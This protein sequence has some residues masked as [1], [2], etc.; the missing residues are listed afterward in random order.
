[1]KTKVFPMIDWDIKGTVRVSG[2]KE[3][4]RKGGDGP[5][6][7]GLSQEFP[8]ARAPG[9]CPAGPAEGTHGLRSQDL[10]IQTRQSPA[11]TRGLLSFWDK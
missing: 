7:Q 9:P 2:R 10:T 11:V 3:G 8:A 5:R 4:T 6:E 1:M